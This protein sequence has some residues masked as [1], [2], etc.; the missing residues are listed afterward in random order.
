MFHISVSGY[1]DINSFTKRLCLKRKDGFTMSFC[2]PQCAAPLNIR[3]FSVSIHTGKPD[4]GKMAVQNIPFAPLVLDPYMEFHCFDLYSRRAYLKGVRKYE[5]NIDI[6]S[7]PG[8]MRNV[9]S[10]V[11]S[12]NRLVCK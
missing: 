1:K 6:L 4:I 10:L 2:I 3:P 5:G 12:H 7:F 11:L 8:R 9:T